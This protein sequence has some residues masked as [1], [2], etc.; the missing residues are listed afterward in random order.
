[1]R[2]NGG[3]LGVIWRKQNAV[4]SSQA[5]SLKTHPLF[6][7]LL[8]IFFPF[9]PLAGTATDEQ[10]CPERHRSVREWGGERQDETLIKRERETEKAL[11]ISR[12]EED[13]MRKTLF[14]FPCCSQLS[15]SRVL[16]FEEL[17]AKYTHMHI[18]PSR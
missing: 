17:V 10:R 16:A 14:N 18:F 12:K 9:L 6:I 3:H 1:M 15:F 8:L 5:V 4:L 2:V 13:E 7:S 11:H